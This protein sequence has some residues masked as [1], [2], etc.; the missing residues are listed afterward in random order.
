[1][2]YVVGLIVLIA[3]IVPAGWIASQYLWPPAAENPS[4]PLSQAPATPVAL[5][6]IEPAEGVVEISGTPGER[7]E[8]LSV[9]E[10]QTVEKGDPLARLQSCEVRSAEVTLIESQIDEAKARLAAEKKLAETKVVSAEL[11]IEQARM[12]DLDIESLQGKI[13]LLKLN[14]ERAQKDYSR[15]ERLHVQADDLVSQQELEGQEL[16]VRQAQ[17]ELTAAAANLKKLKRTRELSE[18]AALADLEAAQAGSKQIEASSTVRSLQTQLEIARAQLALT[19]IVAPRKGTVLKVFVEPGESIG[20]KPILQ[21][22]DLA[23]MVVMA[24][25]HENVIQQIREGQPVTIKS[26]AFPAPY[27]LKGLEGRVDRIGKMVTTPA[28]KSLDP[29]AR[30]DRHVVAV[31]IAIDDPRQSEVAAGFTN[32]QVDVEFR[33]PDASR[34][35]MQA[36]QPAKP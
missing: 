16:L 28:L 17:A 19:R 8:S 24:E 27:H 26:R 2:K 6:W 23:R 29:F 13:T 22:A 7:L 11:G 1:M 5:G 25:V 33:A 34:P 15:L 14:L 3:M 21:L 36:S 30:A 32:L 20:Q 4:G 9:S 31:R 18:K 35:D 10:S 12:Q